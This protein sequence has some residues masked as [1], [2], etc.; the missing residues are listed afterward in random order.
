MTMSSSH[1]HLQRG[2]EEKRKE[3]E[4]PI[5]KSTYDTNPRFGLAKGVSTLQSP[6]L[7]KAS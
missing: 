5:Y 3:K 2:R 1:S 7:R 4:G 6:H